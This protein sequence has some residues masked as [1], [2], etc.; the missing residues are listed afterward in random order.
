MKKFLL[1][2][3]FILGS[4]WFLKKDIKSFKK[5]SVVILEFTCD[6]PFAI[7]IK[8]VKIWS[9]IDKFITDY[10]LPYKNLSAIYF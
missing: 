8:I 1:F 3:I 2:G 9:I 5:L 6:L 10:N 7:F 4:S